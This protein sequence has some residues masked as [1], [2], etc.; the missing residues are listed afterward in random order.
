[1]KFTYD[2]VTDKH[3]IDTGDGFPDEVKEDFFYKLMTKRKKELDRG[4]VE[5]AVSL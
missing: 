3:T 1:M 4:R 5:M 2:D